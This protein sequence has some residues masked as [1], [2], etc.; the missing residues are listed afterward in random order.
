MP[1]A[2]GPQSASQAVLMPQLSVYWHAPSPH[3]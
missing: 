3:V 1:Q 2:Q